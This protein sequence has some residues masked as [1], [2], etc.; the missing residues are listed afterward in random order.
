MENIVEVHSLSKKYDNFQLSDINFH[1]KKGRIVGL[2][3][4]NGNGK[5]TLIKCLLNII[6]FKGKVSF[7]GKDMKEREKEIKEYIGI[8]FDDMPFDDILNAR[9]LSIIMRSIYKSWS[10]D[11]FFQYLDKYNL[12]QKQS[13]KS[14]SKGMKTKLM[15]A[16]ALSHDAKVL[17]LDEP[18]S[19]LDPIFRTEI[20]NELKLYVEEGDRA[21]LFS[22]HIT[23]DLEQIADDIIF[24]H[25]GKIVFS[26]SKEEMLELKDVESTVCSIDNSMINILKGINNDSGN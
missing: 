23:S 8:V 11:T 9:D 13:F 14:Y 7:F 19:G 12:K 26:G 1:I 16:V 17:I 15:L 4:Q 5:T 25:N 21:V 6:H 2:I 20:L 24:V 3:G 22:T 18:T 10:Q